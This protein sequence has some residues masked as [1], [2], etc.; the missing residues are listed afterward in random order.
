M[1][2]STQNFWNES[3]GQIYPT[4]A[5]LNTE[6]LITCKH[7]QSGEKGK[8]I[9]KITKAGTAKFKQWLKQDVE[10]SPMRSEILLKLFFGENV[11]TENSLKLLNRHKQILE[12]KLE[13]CKT[14]EKHLK[15]LVDTGEHPVYYLITVKFGSTIIPAEIKWCDQAIKLIQQHN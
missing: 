15:N 7:E 12:S 5:K 9:Y 6:K 14:V 13:I 4:L 11:D 2:Q 3:N 10:Y 8:K 1:Q